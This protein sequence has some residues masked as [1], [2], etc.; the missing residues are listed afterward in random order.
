MRCR[1]HQCPEDEDLAGERAFCEMHWMMLPWVFK[2]N[3][4]D[5]YG[6]VWW[7]G[8]LAECTRELRRIEGYERS[9]A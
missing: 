6:T 9:K 2:E 4:C 1:A 5:S 7:R 3:L 8:T